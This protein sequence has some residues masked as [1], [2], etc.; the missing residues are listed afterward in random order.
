MNTALYIHIPFCR[1]K[2]SYCSF[3]SAPLDKRAP[4]VIAALKQEMCL[5]PKN[6]KIDTVFF[7]GGTPS[8]LENN[9]LPQLLAAARERFILSENSEITAEANPESV[10][11]ALLA[12]WR[13]AGINRLSFGVQSANDE[14][15]R[16]LGRLH[17][18]V[19]AKKAI[20]YA[21]EAGF[22]HINADLIYNLPGQSTAAFEADLHALL[23]LGIDHLSCYALSIEEGTPLAEMPL[24][25]QDEDIAVEQWMSAGRICAQYGLHRYE[26]SN[27]AKPG[28]QCR[29]NLH[30]WHNDPYFGLGPAAH[31]ARRANGCWL[32]TANVPDINA[33]LQAVFG[34]GTLS[35]STQIGREEEQFESIMLETRT[36][37]GLRLAAFEARYGVRFTERY[38]TAI[39]CACAQGLAT[40]SNTHFALTERGLLLQNRVLLSFM[41]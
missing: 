20:R 21:R 32:R 17:T 39:D 30:Y 41:D 24:P 19:E 37:E 3:V 7:G 12:A 31:G 11:P 5:Y 23:A 36:T 16:L 1:Q 33:Y 28:A 27:Y 40:L 10:T 26:V 18:F 15:L 13:A 35:Q 6:T 9:A 14:N 2:C 29:H 25:I 34:E 4:A 38:K 22:E 8:V